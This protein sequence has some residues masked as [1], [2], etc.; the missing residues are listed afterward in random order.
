[1]IDSRYAFSLS[2]LTFLFVDSAVDDESSVIVY[3]VFF[4]IVHHRL[5]HRIVVGMVGTLLAINPDLSFREMPKKLGEYWQALSK[6]E[7]MPY[8][9]MAIADRLRYDREMAVYEGKEDGAVDSKVA[10]AS[11]VDSS[12]PQDGKKKRKREVV[13]TSDDKAADTN[14]NGEVVAE[15]NANKR[16]NHEGFFTRALNKIKGIFT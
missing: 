12:E 6:E 13:D 1:V 2:E 5:N 4:L 9:K 14:D 3:A 7:R 16:L 15:E 10:A 8:E 11:K